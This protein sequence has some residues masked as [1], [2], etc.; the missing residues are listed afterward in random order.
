MN[1]NFTFKTTLLFVF[2]LSLS[3]INNSRSVLNPKSF[4]T[5]PEL[6]KNFPKMENFIMNCTRNSCRIYI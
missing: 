1:K 2:T 5:M 4:F 6:F 3:N